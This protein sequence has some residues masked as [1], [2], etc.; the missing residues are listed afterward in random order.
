LLQKTLDDNSSTITLL[1]NI[2][3]HDSFFKSL[4][5]VGKSVTIYSPFVSDNVQRMLSTLCD[6]VPPEIVVHLKVLPQFEEKLGVILSTNIELCNRFVV[7]ISQSHQ[8]IIVLGD[9]IIC[10][11]SMNWLSHSTSHNRSNIELSFILCGNKAKEIIKCHY[12]SDVRRIEM[13]PSTDRPAKP[14]QLKVHHVENFINVAPMDVLL[15]LKSLIEDRL[16][17]I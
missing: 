16:L 8:K 2:S 9:D 17:V 4:D 15:R 13:N 6:I 7:D 1:R 10:V 5:V 12:A 11:G 14:F 3:E